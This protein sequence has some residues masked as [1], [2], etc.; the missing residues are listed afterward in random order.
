MPGLNHP[1]HN[2]KV[3]N[4]TIGLPPYLIQELDEYTIPNVFCFGGFTDKLSEVVYNNCTGDF[5]FM[6]L[7]G[8]ICFF[9]MYHYKTNI[10]LITP[11]T[12]LHSEYILEAY[13][14]SFKYLGLN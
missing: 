10:I 1:Q 3:D 2:D 9:V 6:S 7:D 8:N 11:I 12:G 5:P 14:S 13:K 4:C